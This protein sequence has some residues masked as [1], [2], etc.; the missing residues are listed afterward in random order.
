MTGTGEEPQDY[1]A[2]LVVR[3]LIQSTPER[4]FDAWTDHTQLLRWWGPVGVVCTGADC[5]PRPGG[6]YRIMNRLPGGSLLCIRGVFE[7]VERPSRLVFSWSVE[8]LGA[9]TERV[10]VQFVPRGTHTEVVVTHERI[11]DEPTRARHASG[12]EGCLAGLDRYAAQ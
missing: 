9:G 6:A 8:G 4:L 1:V 10:T 2:A 3:R 5:D 12:W 7:I 11:A